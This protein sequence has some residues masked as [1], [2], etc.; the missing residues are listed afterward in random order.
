MGLEPLARPEGRL[1]GAHVA[2]MTLEHQAAQASEDIR[3]DLVETGGGI[4][5]TKVVAPATQDWIET[6]DH[7]AD[8]RADTASTGQRLD[9]LAHPLHRRL[10]GPALKVVAADAALQQLARHACVEVAAKEVKALPAFCEVND[11][12]LLP[13]KLKSEIGQDLPGQLLSRVGL[14]LAR[15]HHDEV[16]RIADEPAVSAV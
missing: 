16:I 2:T 3:V 6:R 11:P 4:A 10:R 8:V 7:L 9:S 1:T 12:R 15:A 14:S 13:V 5:G